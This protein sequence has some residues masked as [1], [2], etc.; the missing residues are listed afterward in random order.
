MWFRTA[1]DLQ[2]KEIQTFDAPAAP[3]D[4]HHFQ[5]FLDGDS[6]STATNSRNH[7]FYDEASEEINYI[8]L[9]SKAWG[10]EAR[11]TV[12]QRSTQAIESSA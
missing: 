11:K 10:F 7:F 4:Q 9:I 1:T 12:T 2:D 8:A 3:T 5:T 6:N